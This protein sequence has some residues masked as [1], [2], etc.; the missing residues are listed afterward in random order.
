M[1]YVEHAKFREP[2]DDAKIWRYMDLAKLFS[3]LDSE[4][5]YFTRIDKF[6]DPFEGVIPP[7]SI[8][9]L[10]QY[11][12]TLPPNE[13]DK[14]LRGVESIGTRLPIRLIGV[15]CWHLNDYESAAMWRL[16]LKSNEGVAIQSTHR[17]LKESLTC[18]E[19][20]YVGQVEYI[21]YD[22]QGFSIDN[23]FN[24]C[25]HKRASFAHERELRAVMLMEME[26]SHGLNLRIDVR[27]LVERIY[28]APSSD[29]WFADIVR[30]MVGRLGYDFEVLQSRLDDRPLR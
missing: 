16:Y 24:A 12:S 27:K 28:V 13:R 21:D 4:S 22:I 29:P 1:V 30:R 10:R 5:L 11:A 23:I 3:L 25:L 18:E 14:F 8:A 7:A 26:Q 17:K 6:E 9:A 19:Q 2:S 15:N 20:V